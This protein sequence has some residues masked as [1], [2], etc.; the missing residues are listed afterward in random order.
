[1]AMN[2]G[3]DWAERQPPAPQWWDALWKD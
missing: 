1:V 3:P 2:V